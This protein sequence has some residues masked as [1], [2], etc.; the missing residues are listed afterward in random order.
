MKRQHEAIVKAIVN[1]IEIHKYP[2]TVRE[3][4]EAVGLSSTSSVHAHLKRMKIMGIIETDVESNQSRAIRVPGYV[5]VKEEDYKKL[6]SEQ[7][8][9]IQ[10]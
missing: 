2:P 8:K 10:R 1:Y 3:I 7:E 6:I 9:N 4:A 5:F